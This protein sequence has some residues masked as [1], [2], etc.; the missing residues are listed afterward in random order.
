MN[1]S[2][3][4]PVNRWMALAACVV[5]IIG[6]GAVWAGVSLV[7][8]NHAGWMSVVAALDA[9]LLLRLAGWP[10]G[11]QRVALALAVT[12]LTVVAANFLIATA[13]IG[14]AMGMRPFEAIPRMSSELAMLY[15][16]TNNGWAELIWVVLA[17]L[18]AWRLAR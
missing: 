3:V 7:T 4:K 10:A 6:V 5:A 16:S 17:L 8:R 18:V 15:A 13:Q 9:A 12:A 11:R 2:P 14:R 1:R